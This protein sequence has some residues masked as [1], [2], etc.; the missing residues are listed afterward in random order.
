MYK[1]VYV[2]T[3][4]SIFFFFDN[5]VPGTSTAMYER[6]IGRMFHEKIPC[7]FFF[8]SYRTVR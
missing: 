4:R 2:C 1:G 5:T 7:F 6:N 3:G 8:L